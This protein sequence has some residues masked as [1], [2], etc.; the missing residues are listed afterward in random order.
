M[1]R[2]DISGFHFLF[3]TPFLCYPFSSLYVNTASFSPIPSSIWSA[4]LYF[5][6]RPFSVYLYSY[7]DTLL[8]FALRH[9]GRPV[10]LDGA[11]FWR[12]SWSCWRSA[13]C[14]QASFR[15]RTNY[16]RCVVWTWVWYSLG[17]VKDTLAGLGRSQSVGTEL[18]S[19]I[20][21]HCMFDVTKRKDMRHVGEIMANLHN[22]NEAN[23]SF[24]LDGVVT[25]SPACNWFYGIANWA[26]W[27]WDMDL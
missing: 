2:L 12:L 21:T 23:W 14:D 1:L 8:R 26:Y 11:I 13:I 5:V 20:R 3:Y 27:A 24:V 7:F 22:I 4:I 9:A 17:H 18:L 25:I 19:E 15:G 6:C 16:M 10:F